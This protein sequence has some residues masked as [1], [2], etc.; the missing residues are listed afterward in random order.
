M[1]HDLKAPSQYQ[2]V[3]IQ[4]LKH[5]NVGVA[6]I[7]QI[8]LVHLFLLPSDFPTPRSKRFIQMTDHSGSLK[9]HVQKRHWLHIR[10]GWFYAT[11]HLKRRDIWPRYDFKWASL[12]LSW[13]SREKKNEVWTNCERYLPRQVTIKVV[14]QTAR[15]FVWARGIWKSILLSLMCSKFTDKYKIFSSVYRHTMMKTQ[16]KRFKYIYTSKKEIAQ[17]NGSWEKKGG[18]VLMRRKSSCVLLSSKQPDNHICRW[19]H[20]PD[21]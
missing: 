12:L 16:K 17:N 21:N 20:E 13:G 6:Q 19:S 2:N 18:K 8:T 4:L 10:P 3:I 9:L 7:H 1:V 11:G 15:L 14:R 5:L